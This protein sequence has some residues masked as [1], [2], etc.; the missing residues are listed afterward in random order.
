MSYNTIEFASSPSLLGAKSSETPIDKY[1]K[2]PNPAVYPKVAAYDCE[3]SPDGNYIGAGYRFSPYL[4][5]FEK[6]GDT[7]KQAGAPNLSNLDNKYSSF[8]FCFEKGY[9]AMGRNDDSYINIYKRSGNTYSF[10]KSLRPDISYNG[11]TYS[12]AFSPEGDYLAVCYYNSN[13]YKYHLLLYRRSGDN[14]TESTLFSISQV[15][16][17]C[18]FS[19]NGEY[20]VACHNGN[21]PHIFVYQ[22]QPG[23]GLVKLPDSAIS[24]SQAPDFLSISGDGE[25]LA[26]LGSGK[27]IVCKKSNNVYDALPDTI[28]LPAGV[29]IARFALSPDSNFLAVTHGIAPFISI[30]KRIGN[31]FVRVQSPEILPAGGAMGCSFSPNSEFLVVSHLESPYVTFYKK[32]EDAIRETTF[33]TYIL[34]NGG[35]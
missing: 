31:S 30:Y 32:H 29:N 23:G 12:C 21:A 16:R 5:S 8:S 33:Y 35:L 34:P 27:V 1:V 13:T 17:F 28:E 2:L 9:L 10:L 4:M 24:T 11:R 14:F 18:A 3:F 15:V 20:L 25:Y 19:N 7:F 26:S 22:R 6:T